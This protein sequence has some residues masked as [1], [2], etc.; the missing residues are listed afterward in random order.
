MVAGP[1]DAPVNWSGPYYIII[2]IIMYFRILLTQV[3]Y[4]LN[5]ISILWQENYILFDY[6]LFLDEQI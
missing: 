6:G 5:I 4:S 3:F 1:P 2:I